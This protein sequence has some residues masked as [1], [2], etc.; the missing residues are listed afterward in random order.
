MCEKI[1]YSY[2]IIPIKLDD[3]NGIQ[4]CFRRLKEFYKKEEPLRGHIKKSFDCVNLIISKTNALHEQQSRDKD[5]PEYLDFSYNNVFVLGCECIVLNKIF[6]KLITEI[7]KE[8]PDFTNKKSYI[9]T[10]KELF[11]NYLGN[12]IK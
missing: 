5:V 9:A 6:T 12:K 7:E 10:E 1:N 8:F 4:R 3:W 11:E 2:I